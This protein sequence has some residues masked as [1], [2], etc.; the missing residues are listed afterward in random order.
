MA[1]GEFVLAPGVP[2]SVDRGLQIRGDTLRPANGKS[3]AQFLR[4]TLQI[5]MTAAG[6]FDEASSVVISAQ[7]TKS[8]VNTSSSPYAALGARFRVTRAGVDV[9]SKELIARDT[10]G[11]QFIGAIAITEAEQRYTAL[12]SKLVQT[13]VTD[14]DFRAAVTAN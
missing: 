6:R 9:F 3:F 8:E 13:L 1:L 4:E 7:L 2:P 11:F 14:P 5:E 12:Y 10:W